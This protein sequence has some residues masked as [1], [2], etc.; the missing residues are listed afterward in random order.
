MYDAIVVGARC[1]GSPTAMLLAQRGYHA[2]VV[3]KAHF[4]LDTPATHAAKLPAGAALKRWGLLDQV[5][6]SNCTPIS[7]WS[8]DVGPLVLAGVAPH[9]HG[10]ASAYAPRRR[11]LDP[12][13]AETAV[14]EGAEFRQDFT[15]DEVLTSDG[16]V[17]G[18]RGHT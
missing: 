14:G 16:R 9:A 10:V 6:A 15:V 7:S 5:I 1:A 11:I 17:H 4:P 18:I 2:L 8:I 12:V 3:D 13:L